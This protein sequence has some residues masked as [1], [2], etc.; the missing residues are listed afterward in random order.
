MRRR[1]QTAHNIQ[2]C[3]CTQQAGRNLRP[4]I[5]FT[6]NKHKGEAEWLEVL[7]RSLSWVI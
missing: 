7:T 2:Q 1:L 5:F 4:N 6:Q 3:S